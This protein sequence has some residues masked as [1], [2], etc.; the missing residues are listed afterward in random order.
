V[1]QFAWQENPLT[2]R[3]DKR[4]LIREHLEEDAPASTEPATA[5]RACTTRAGPAPVAPLPPI[6]NAGLP[7][8]VLPAAAATAKGGNY[9]D[10]VKLYLGLALKNQFWI[11]CGVIPAQPGKLD[12]GFRQS[13]RDTKEERG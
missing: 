9:M 8:P 10:Q 12:Y 4:R 11:L 13:R 1:V 2:K 3:L 7:G 6:P 5:I